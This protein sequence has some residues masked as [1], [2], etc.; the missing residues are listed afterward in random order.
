MDNLM[1][2]LMAGVAANDTVLFMS[3]RTEDF[4]SLF[5]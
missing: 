3:P 2:H 1:A 5:I 4:I